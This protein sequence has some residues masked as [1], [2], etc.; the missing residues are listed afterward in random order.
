MASARL[1]ARDRAVQETSLWPKVIM[2][3][4]LPTRCLAIDGKQSVGSDVWRGR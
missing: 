3:D 4:Y 2:P 1:N